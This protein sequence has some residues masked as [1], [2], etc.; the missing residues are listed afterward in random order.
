MSDEI[1]PRFSPRLIGKMT[2]ALHDDTFAKDYPVLFDVLKPEYNERK[3][4]VREAGSFRVSI[5]GSVYRIT[6]ECPTEGIQTVLYTSTLVDLL[7]QME[8]HLGQPSILWTE[9]FNA[10]RRARRG[11]DKSLD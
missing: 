4:L 3:R 7:E 9:T 8:M 5:D 6:I 1:V 2:A 10:K 11:L